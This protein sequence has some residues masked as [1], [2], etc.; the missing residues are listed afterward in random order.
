MYKNDKGLRTETK[1]SF[2]PGAQEATKEV[3]NCFAKKP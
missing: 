1:E 2:G 3:L